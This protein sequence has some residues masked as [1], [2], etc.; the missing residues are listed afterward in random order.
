MGLC[1]GRAVAVGMC[2]N[3]CSAVSEGKEVGAVGVRSLVRSCVSFRRAR[4]A[5]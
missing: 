1:R 2:N 5:Q 4:R 3:A